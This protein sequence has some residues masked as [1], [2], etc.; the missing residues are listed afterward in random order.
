MAYRAYFSLFL[1]ISCFSLNPVAQNSCL[2]TLLN[3]DQSAKEAEELQ[4]I[5][6]ERFEKEMQQFW[7][8]RSVTIS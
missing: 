7:N 6:D 1:G 8:E 3:L 5:V 4:D 2:R